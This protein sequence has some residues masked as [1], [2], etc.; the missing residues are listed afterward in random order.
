M[1]A[2]CSLPRASCYAPVRRNRRCRSPADLE[3]MLQS[4]TTAYAGL[5]RGE[6][7]L[8]RGRLAEGIEAF[9]R[10]KQAPQ[11]VVQPVSA[12]ESLCGGGS[13]RRGLAELEL[14]VKR[15]GEAADVF[16][17]DMPTLHYLPPVYYWLGRA[18]EGVGSTAEARNSRT[19]P[20]PACRRDPQIRSPPTRGAGSSEGVR[21]RGFDTTVSDSLTFTA[22]A[23]QCPQGRRRR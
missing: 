11:F 8:E 1:R 12:R 21:H 19:V 10:R 15:R 2:R 6:I 5:I 14:C 13:L 3:K 18:Q 23:C 7:A 17:Y 22:S 9:R 16:F 4:Q 20:Q